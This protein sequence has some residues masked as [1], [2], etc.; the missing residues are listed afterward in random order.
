MSRGCRDLG[1][2]VNHVGRHTAIDSQECCLEIW[3]QDG[4]E[5]S[6]NVGTS[7]DVGRIIE[8]RI[9]KQDDVFHSPFRTRTP[10]MTAGLVIR[11]CA[12]SFS[13][14]SWPRN[15]QSAPT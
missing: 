3:R 8:N 10:K 5:L 15:P 6:D 9:T 1:N 12:P 11:N 4:G 2:L 14:S 7:I 13:R